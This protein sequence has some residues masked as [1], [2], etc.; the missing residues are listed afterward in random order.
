VNNPAR[1][2]RGIAGT[3]FT[4]LPVRQKRDAAFEHM[5]CFILVGVVMRRRPATGR[6][7]IRSHCEFSAHVFA[8]KMNDYFFAERAQH[9][10]FALPGYCP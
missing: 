9:A 6:S 7:N 10:P 4:P 3:T 1:H 2:E 8:I 5:K